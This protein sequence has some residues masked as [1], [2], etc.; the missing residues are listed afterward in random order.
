MAQTPFVSVVVPVL[1]DPRLKYCLESLKGQTYPQDRYEI[2]VVDNGSGASV[3]DLAKSFGGIILTKEAKRSC[4]AARNKGI[5]MARGEILAFTDADCVPAGDWL[6]NGVRR[7]LSIPRCGILAGRVELTFKDPRR[8]SIFELYDSIVHFQQEFYIRTRKFGGTNNLF[9]F[10]K[11]VDDIGLI[12]SET[13]ISTYE[14]VDF[15]QRVYRA[16]YIQAY[17]TDALVCHP[18]RRTF[19]EVYKKMYRVVD[20][21]IRYRKKWP[22]T[23]AYFAEV[24]LNNAKWIVDRVIFTCSK[25]VYRGKKIMLLFLGIFCLY[26]R[27]ILYLM[28]KY[29]K[30]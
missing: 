12:D 28:L 13:F 4:G 2:I 11:V 15:G 30:A 26:L 9:T 14:D 6:E 8:P 1:D 22:A 21:S 5:S 3:D 20:G 29:K 24:G 10:R 25:P 7:L 17:S 16:G 18:A 27:C 19:A 23:P